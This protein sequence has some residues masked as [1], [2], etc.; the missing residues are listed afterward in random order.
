MSRPPLMDDELCEAVLAGDGPVP[1]GLWG[2]ASFAEDARALRT[3]PAPAPDAVLQA[4][5]DAPP[6]LRSIGPARTRR[7]AHA[8]AG[9]RVVVGASAALMALTGAAAAGVLPGEAQHA[10][11]TVVN[12]VSPFPDLP[13]G[14][15]GDAT[16]TSSTGGTPSVSTGGGHGSS[17]GS[18]T[19]TSTSS[20]SPLAA[21]AKSTSDPAS[22]LGA[23]IAADLPPDWAPAAGVE[24][25]GQ[26]GE[27]GSDRAV[28]TPAG[29]NGN[30]NGNAN[31][32]GNGS[33][34]P[35]KATGHDKS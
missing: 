13:D 29:G 20:S 22:T 21:A 33:D 24:P 26:S 32:N 11:V 35:D 7:R 28:T 34:P 8:G 31:E 14:S 19:S 10:V 4:M 18:N 3:I 15:A 27:T 23:A 6:R 16:A 30:V 2:L 12:S 9:A 17:S 1:H 5:F 25:P